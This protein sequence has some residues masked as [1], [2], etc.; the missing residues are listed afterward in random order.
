MIGQ[1]LYKTNFETF[2]TG[3]SWEVKTNLQLMCFTLFVEIL[4][5]QNF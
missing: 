5:S 4:E 1:K 2:N 3:L